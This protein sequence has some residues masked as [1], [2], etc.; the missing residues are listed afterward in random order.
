MRKKT[1]IAVTFF[2]INIS[3]SY[4]Q[5]LNVEMNNQM[6]DS[7]QVRLTILK[8]Q[9]F[10]NPK[11]EKMFKSDLLSTK[12]DL[13][14]FLKMFMVLR[15]KRKTIINFEDYTFEINED[16]EKNVWFAYIYNHK[17]SFTGNGTYF[18]IVKNNCRVLI[19]ESL[20]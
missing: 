6:I 4:S 5:K 18:A 8:S 20:K 12:S 9:K 10:Y 2:L 15:D 14:E 7:F 3:L 17:I 1:I 13:I 11:K 19:C 16:S